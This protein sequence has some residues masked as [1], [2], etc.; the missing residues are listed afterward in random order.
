MDIAKEIESMKVSID[1]ILGGA[2]H[3]AAIGAT[4]DDGFVSVSDV[5][6]V[7]EELLKTHTLVPKEPTPEML[8]V[9][10]CDTWKADVIEVAYKAMLEAAKENS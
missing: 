8:E 9:L 6:S 2:E 7:V 10:W 4:F 1:E 5:R 3:A